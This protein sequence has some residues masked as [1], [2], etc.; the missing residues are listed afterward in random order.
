MPSVPT[1]T[2][3]SHYEQAADVLRGVEIRNPGDR[4]WEA[5]LNSLPCFR[6]DQVPSDDEIV[7]AIN[8]FL[9]FDVVQAACHKH[10]IRMLRFHYD[11]PWTTDWPDDKLAEIEPYDSAYQ[12]S[13]N[14]D[15]HPEELSLLISGWYDGVVVPQGQEW[16]WLFL[17]M[18]GHTRTVCG[19]NC[20]TLRGQVAVRRL[21]LSEA[22]RISELVRKLSV[23]FA[24][25]NVRGCG[26]VKDAPQATCMA[27]VG[28][29]VALCL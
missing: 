26:S 7:S 2:L 1:F 11:R 19:W 4:G 5:R 17:L 24:C 22:N 12:I 10:H 28:R 3:S 14:V 18:V 15:L 27:R 29:E 23:R 21:T 16:L 20:F 25:A 9:P 8:T 13:L 6:R